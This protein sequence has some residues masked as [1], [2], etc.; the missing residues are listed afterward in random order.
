MSAKILKSVGAELAATLPANDK[1][2]YKKPNLVKLNFCLM[3][4]F[5]LSSGNGYDGSMLN[6]VLALPYW[7]TF[8]GHPKG[9]WLGFVSGAQNLGSIFFFPIVAYL[10]NKFGRKKTI[11]M[12]YI[13]L[14][15][16]AGMQTGAVNSSMFVSSRVIVGIASAFFGGC[17]PLLMTETAYPTQRGVFTSL[18]MCGWYVGKSSIVLM[19]QIA[20]PTD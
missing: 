5:L 1:P 16:G 3:S 18:Y 17:A 9:A 12:G 8:M 11:F 7:D 13:F 10:S 6:G 14:L 15:L 4:I 2:W 20:F 19:K